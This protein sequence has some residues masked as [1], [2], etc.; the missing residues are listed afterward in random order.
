M[1]DIVKNLFMALLAKADKSPSK[2]VRMHKKEKPMNAYLDNNPQG[3]RETLHQEFKRLEAAQIIAIKWHNPN[4]LLQYIQLI[5]AEQLALQVGYSRL[6]NRFEQARQLVESELID[7][8]HL[9][10]I[11]EPLFNK[12]QDSGM[13]E[14]FSVDEPQE[15]I[16]AIRAADEMLRLSDTQTSEIDERHFSTAVFS[17]SKKLKRIQGKVARIIRLRDSDIPN[18]LDHADVFQLFGVVPM[19]H[20]VYI[21]GP[22]VIT[23]KN[24]TSISADFPPCVGIWPEYIVSVT[25]DK[26]ISYITS[27]ENLATYMRYVETEKTDDEIV[28]YTA[29]IPSPAFRAFYFSLIQQLPEVPLRHWGDIDVGGFTIVHIL[30]KTS[31]RPVKGYRMSPTDYVLKPNYARLSLKEC[32]WLEKMSA[33]MSDVNQQKIAEVLSQGIK[34]EQEAFY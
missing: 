14:G 4:I 11:C 17:D 34:F 33:N 13:F 1:K 5:D 28:L 2:Q 32:S 29:G 26:P 20:P 12:W 19:K 6:A 24:N 10:S 31:S 23:S 21:A 30:E 22:L 16:D 3:I 9:K 18:E 8:P 25:N 27:I 7:S 15:L